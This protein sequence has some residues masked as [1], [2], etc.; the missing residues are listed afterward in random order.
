MDEP[1]VQHPRYCPDVAWGLERLDL[2][3]PTHGAD[4]CRA[5]GRG[6]EVH[7][8]RQRAGHEEDPD[9]PR[10]LLRADVDAGRRRRGRG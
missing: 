5:T 6:V 8:C 10:L 3:F 9:R 2:R 7:A 4:E 1:T